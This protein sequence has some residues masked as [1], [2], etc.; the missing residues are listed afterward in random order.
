VNIG[1]FS[2]AVFEVMS[3]FMSKNAGRFVTEVES[4]PL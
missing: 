1:G 4:I 3:A 2:D